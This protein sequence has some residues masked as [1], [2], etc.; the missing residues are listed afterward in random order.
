MEIEAKFSFS[1]PAA[2]DAWLARPRLGPFALG[3]ARLLHL[4]D[5]YLDTDDRACLAQGY[6]CRVRLQGDRAIAT[7]KS[8]ADQQEGGDGVRRR[9]E[10]EVDLPAPPFAAPTRPGETAPAWQQPDAWPEGPARALALRLSSGRPLRGLATLWQERHERPVRAYDGRV[11]ASLTLDRVSF[12]DGAPPALELECELTR[13]GDEQAMAR[14]VAAL[15]EEHSFTPEPRSKLA[16]ALQGVALPAGVRTALTGEMLPSTE[17]DTAR[18]G[19]TPPAATVAGSGQNAASPDNAPD[20][21]NRD[22]AASRTPPD[23]DPHTAEQP[24]SG[25]DDTL[26]GRDPATRIAIALAQATPI[27]PAERLPRLRRALALLADGRNADPAAPAAAAR[28]IAAARQTDVDADGAL[29]IGALAL[30]ALLDERADDD[31]V[32]KRL[33][34]RRARELGALTALGASEATEAR[35]LALVLHLGGALAEAGV[36][37]VAAATVSER[38]A[39]MYL[40]GAFDDSGLEKCCAALWQEAF[41]ATLV[42]RP[43]GLARKVAGLRYDLPLADAGR[44]ILAVRLMQLQ[45]GLGGVRD[46]ADVEALHDARVAARRLRTALQ[47]LKGVFPRRE[48][49]PLAKQLRA[50]ARSLG[51][52]RDL[53][54]LIARVRDDA[55]AHGEEDALAPALARMSEARQTARS[56]L[57]AEIDAPEHAAW[58]TNMHTLLDGGARGEKGDR[59]LCDA[60]PALLW[61]GYG[62][63]RAYAPDIENADNT[64]LHELRKE[65]RRLRYGLEFFQ[66]LLGASAGDLIEQTVALQDALG[67]LHDSVALHEALQRFDAP[68]PALLRTLADITRGRQAALALWPT[69]NGRDFRDALGAACAA[70]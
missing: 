25:A 42:L 9:D 38:G 29:L 23:I 69:V 61:R 37:G 1:D 53:D 18:A 55:R 43:A 39:T 24:G 57:L 44:R 28:D 31:G 47:L 67:A 12:A 62:R 7:L 45:E 10:Q 65:T 27:V 51:A 19:E 20:D 35:A 8:L 32:A 64:R 15:R 16:R 3:P 33:G 21:R 50:L 49:G 6:A 40:V 14:I 60:V 66:E 46:D 63:V 68:E 56:A 13:D 54:V 17:R 58:L 48:T 41:E 59:R 52:V 22:A 2:F 11:I 4:S 5:S 36:E 34:G 30:L 26:P 70:L